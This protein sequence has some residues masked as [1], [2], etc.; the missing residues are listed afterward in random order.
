[1][2]F[3]AAPSETDLNVLKNDTPGVDTPGVGTPMIQITTHPTKGTAVVDNGLVKY[4]RTTDDKTDD[5]FKYKFK[6]DNGSFSN[7]SDVFLKYQP[8]CCVENG[9]VNIVF[10]I[11]ISFSISDSEL[12]QLQASL[13][14]VIN[15]LKNIQEGGDVTINIL[16]LKFAS[17]TEI[18]RT[19]NSSTFTNPKYSNVVDDY[20]DIT[21]Y[22]NVELDNRDSIGDY[23][24]WE[25]A[26]QALDVVS[27][28]DT[29]VPNFLFFVSDGVPTANQ[30]D[31]EVSVWKN[32]E[33][34]S[35]EVKGQ[36]NSNNLPNAVKAITDWGDSTPDMKLF[37]IDIEN[38]DDKE[39]FND[40]VKEYEGNAIYTTVDNF[41]QDLEDGINECINNI[42]DSV[43]VN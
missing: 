34:S 11:D 33:I 4:T 28:N 32:N 23:T 13:V 36:N 10:Q 2:R 43:E 30:D 29:I 38:N 15:N 24:N 1:M 18:L 35:G 16:M 5:E 21:D 19:D 20:T 14:K 42:C 6:Y 8:F 12:D 40:I 37:G 39:T 26:F 7:I 41:E 22:I 9:I 31:T 25:A 3:C 17:R 27:Q